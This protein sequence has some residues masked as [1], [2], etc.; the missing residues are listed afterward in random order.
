MLSVGLDMLG[1]RKQ[2]GAMRILC[3]DWR[4]LG[5]THDD[6]GTNGQ[7]RHIHIRLQHIRPRDSDRDMQ[8]RAI[9]LRLQVLR[10]RL[11]LLR[12]RL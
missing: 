9:A 11:L 6:V 3:A 2:P 5:S 8:G 12:L 4:L 7:P 10:L 1:R